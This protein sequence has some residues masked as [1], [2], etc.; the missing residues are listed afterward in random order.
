MVF[1]Y[2]KSRF[3][4][5]NQLKGILNFFHS[6][7]KVF[8]FGIVYDNF[9]IRM[10]LYTIGDFLGVSV[11]QIEALSAFRWM[12][13]SE[14][15]F[16]QCPV[17]EEPLIHIEWTSEPMSHCF[18]Q[19]FSATLPNFFNA[20]FSERLRHMRV[21]KSAEFRPRKQTD[22]LPQV[23]AVPQGKPL[24]KIFSY[25]R[26]FDELRVYEIQVVKVDSEHREFARGF[27]FHNRAVSRQ[28]VFEEEI[29]P[30]R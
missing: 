20:A 11:G 6:N 1:S 19:S 26:M 13:R 23:S 28:T 10:T 21:Q 3:L 22:V 4:W 27:D 7:I 29:F 8:N 2:F 15:S 24:E 16:A 18:I 25:D 12:D 14:F 17:P 5:Q 30:D 9:L